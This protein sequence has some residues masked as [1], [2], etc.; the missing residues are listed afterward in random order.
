MH[1]LSDIY[2]IGNHFYDKRANSKMVQSS[3]AVELGM[4]IPP[5]CMSNSKNHVV[6]FAKNYEEMGIKTLRAHWMERDDG[7]VY[8]LTTQKVK[9]S[10][11]SAKPEEAFS[12][13]PV[14]IQKYIPKKYELRVTVMGPHFFTCKLHSQ[15]QSE[16]TGAIDW[17]QG[18]DFGL[19]HEMIETPDIL[20][21]FCTK[22]LR[23]LHIN[24]GCFDFIL[25][26]DDRTVFLECNPNGQ[27][28]WI[29]DE[30]KVPMSEAIVDCLVNRLYV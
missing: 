7:L 18:Y 5:T 28:G 11:L 1:Y 2:S 13:A 15:E 24:F 14:F 21:D 12:M 29:E 10:S 6:D 22:F 30:C 25:T 16:E 27:W 26:P 3:L 19:R 17:R 4:E 8:D 9:S 23:R 20:R